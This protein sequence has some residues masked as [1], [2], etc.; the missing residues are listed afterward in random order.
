MKIILASKDE[1]ETVLGESDRNQR[2]VDLEAYKH[3]FDLFIREFRAFVED[4]DPG[5]WPDTD[6][7]IGAEKVS[8]AFRVNELI[9]K[10][11]GAWNKRRRKFHVFR[12][13]IYSY[14]VSDPLYERRASAP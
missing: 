7:M 8:A 3:F 9:N 1:L 14:D 5:A 10:H 13:H 4:R 2:V 6:M 11:Y 12:D